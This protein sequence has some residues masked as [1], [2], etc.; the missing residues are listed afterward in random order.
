MGVDV[1]SEG[2]TGSPGS[3]GSL[4]LPERCPADPFPLRPYADT[5]LADTPT[6]FPTSRAV[7]SRPTSVG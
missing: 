1:A 6:R 7:L 3:D 2:D 5:P 4:T